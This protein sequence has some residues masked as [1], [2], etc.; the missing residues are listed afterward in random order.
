MHPIHH[1]YRTK[2]AQLKYN[3]L[4]GMHGR[5]STDTFFSSV[6]SMHQNKAAQIFV[7]NVAFTRVFLIPSKAEAPNTL[8]E[9]IQDVGIPH[10]IHANNAPELQQGKWKQIV[11][12]YQIK[13]TATEPHS[14]WQNRAELAI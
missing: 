3:Y 2:Q 5:F 14:S 1:H 10:Q 13:H 7:N 9:F 4:G 12:D 11:S 6:K 8:V